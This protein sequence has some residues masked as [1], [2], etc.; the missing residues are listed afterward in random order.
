[1]NYKNSAIGLLALISSFAVQ[2]QTGTTIYGV[3]DAGVRYSDGLGLTATSSPSTSATSTTALANGVDRSGRFGF[4]GT[5]DL[6]D[7][8]Q[9]LFKL[10]SDL[11]LN[12][13]ST[14]VNIGTDKNT[15][16]ATTNKF[17]ER[18]ASV[19]LA[20]PYGSFIFGRQQSVIRD[21]IDDIDAINGRFTS[22]N[23]NLQFT[24]LNSPSLVTSA[25]TYYGTGDGGNGSMMRQDNAVKYIEQVGPVT[26]TLLYSFGGVAGDS[27]AGSSTEAA[28]S[29]KNGP[30]LLSAGY[31]DLNNI[32]DTLK[33]TAYTAGG[34]VTLGDW[35]IAANFGSNTADNTATTQIKT[36][37]YSIGATYAATQAIDFTLGYYNVDRSWTKDV[38]PDAKIDR[39]IGFVEYKFSKQT[40]AYL[41]F[42]YNKWGG[43]E[44][45]FQGGVAN[46]ATTSGFTIG[47]NHKI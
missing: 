39:V 37:I 30:L 38:K 22:F 43:D 11:Y 7:G 27:E 6:G 15:A 29:Y 46:K 9:A 5:E 25:A 24:S 35:Q 42:D 40:L 4:S 3:L 41:E 21:I 26:G 19:G 10:E 1:M 13:G 32:T 33:L 17:F 36:D 44:T 18:E 14:N 45:Q 12:T 47:L 20:T 16:A 2:A 34:R 28:L 31:E 23:P 8:Y